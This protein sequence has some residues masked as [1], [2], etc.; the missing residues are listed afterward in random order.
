MQGEGELEVGAHRVLRLQGTHLGTG[1]RKIGGGEIASERN[2][3]RYGGR[4]M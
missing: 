2:G 3:Q 4:E 1:G